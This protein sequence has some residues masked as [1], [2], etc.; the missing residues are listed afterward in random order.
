MDI[1]YE[2]VPKLVS[3]VSLQRPYPKPYPNPKPHPDPKPYPSP[4]PSQSD[5]GPYALALSEAL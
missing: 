2:S 3:F 1:F 4:K 5:A